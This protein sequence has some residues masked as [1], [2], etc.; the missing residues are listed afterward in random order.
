[1]VQGRGEQVRRLPPADLEWM[2]VLTPPIAIP[3]KTA[4][5]YNGLKPASYT[6]G[7][8]TRK[9]EARIR[10]GGD[11]PHQFLFNAFDDAAFDV[12]PGLERYWEAFS[13]M[14]AREIHVAGS[15]PSMF[16]PVSRKEVGTALELLLRHRF[17]W[18][19]RLVS[20]W[21]PQPEMRA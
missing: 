21:Q 2:V 4:A 9:L 1:M 12:F 8:L 6:N 3:D 19:A 5:A 17:Q 7:A 14:G 10:G 20:T 15:G 11:V 18:D 16:A 13:S